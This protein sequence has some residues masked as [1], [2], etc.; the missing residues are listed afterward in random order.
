MGAAYFY[1]LTDSTLEAALPVLIERA[2]AAG[3]KVAV[4]G[5]DAEVLERLDRA[6]WMGAEEAFLPH[7]LAGGA[8]DA[9]QPVLLCLPDQAAANAAACLM[10]VGGVDVTEADV[11]GFERVCV[12]FDGMDG[13]AVATARG[14]WKDLT[15]A[16]CAALYWAQEDGRWT[17]KA[18]NGVS[19]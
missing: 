10:A 13:A 18:E 5:P 6:M 19:G 15:G 7:G 16:G 1:H 11:A 4:R 14:Q 17:K 8:H 12:L 3:W 2:R 9:L